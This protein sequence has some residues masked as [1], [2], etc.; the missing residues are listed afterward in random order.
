MPFRTIL[1]S[2]PDLFTVEIVAKAIAIRYRRDAQGTLAIGRQ[3]W[4]FKVLDVRRVP[5]LTPTAN[6]VEI[7]YALDS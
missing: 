5:R 4:F 2:K 3:P 6:L 7:S 1:N